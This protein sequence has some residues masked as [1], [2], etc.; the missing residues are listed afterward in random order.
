MAR[1][2]VGNPYLQNLAE[3]SPPGAP[4]SD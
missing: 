2:R 1:E 3:L 4:R